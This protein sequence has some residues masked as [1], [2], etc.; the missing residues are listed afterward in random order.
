MSA[1]LAILDHL[2]HYDGEDADRLLLDALSVVQPERQRQLVDAIIQR[3]T[4]IGLQGLPAAYSQ[5]EPDARQLIIDHVDAL[6]GALRT[7]VRSSKAQTRQNALEIIALSGDARL[8]YLATHAIHD[9][10]PRIRAQAAGT[11]SKLADA[12]S[13]RTLA[14]T[15]RL[16]KL[17]EEEP[18]RE[19][20][21]DVLRRLEE[22]RGFLINAL[23]E[24]VNHYESHHR[25]EVIEAALPWALDLQDVLLKQ[26][27]IS[28]GKLTFTIQELLSERLRPEHVPYVYIALAF[29]DLRRRLVALLQR[30]KDTAFFVEMIRWSWLARDPRVRRHLSAIRQVDWLNDE[31]DTAFNLPPDVA[32]RAADWILKLGLP[33]NRKISL[34]LNLMIVDHADVNRAAV[35]AL[36]QINSPDGTMALQGLLDHD[37]ERVQRIARIELQRRERGSRQF[38]R[39]RVLRNRPDDWARM[40]ESAGISEEFESIWQN[41]ERLDATLAHRAGHLAFQF[42][43]DFETRLQVKLLSKTATDRLRALRLVRTLAIGSRFEKDVFRSAN[44]SLADIRAV[45]IAILG[46][47]GGETSRRILERSLQDKAPEVIAAGI[48]ALDAVQAPRRLELVEPLVKSND[49]DV[50]ASAI[51]CLLRLKQPK[52]ASEL[53]KMLIDH[54]S[55]HRCAALWIIDQLRLHTILDRVRVM[56][57]SDPD[58]RIARISQHV[59]K[60]LE[61]H[62]QQA[63][64]KRKVVTR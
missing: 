43:T 62:R 36:T 4:S 9:G 11:L 1:R 61:R 23:A 18:N 29:P 30:S 59:A 3:G 37:D 12:L 55:D 50:R 20:A 35:R 39:S 5:L 7:S 27:T 48:D 28:R 2:Q 64:S 54:R 19:V 8:A 42:V 25:N 6:A 15:R 51:R 24:A 63:Q 56:A 46:T 40:I 44:D 14:E 32:S 41:F 34:L 26:S 16:S 45:A 33:V 57:T 21:N 52:A 10:S 58:R 13:N 31:F 49:S 38:K 22:D 60:R 53:L 47:I 17:G